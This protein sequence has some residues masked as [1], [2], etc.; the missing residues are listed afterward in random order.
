MNELAT[1]TGFDIQARYREAVTNLAEALDLRD[2]EFD[3]VVPFPCE[4]TI[5]L[6]AHEG[7][8]Y[9]VAG[10]DHGPELGG[11]DDETEESWQ[12]SQVDETFVNLQTG[13]I[14]AVSSRVV[15]GEQI[16]GIAHACSAFRESQDNS[17]ADY[18]RWRMD[19]NNVHESEP[20]KVSE[21]DI[22]AKIEKA[23]S[24]IEDRNPKLF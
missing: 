8:T 21:Y 9:L 19:G 11:V 10:D 18:L 4:Y 15:D 17:F 1:E 16:L 2:G 7:V 6:I 20:M 5:V 12:E 24:I 23:L 22:L 14:R 13:E 3:D